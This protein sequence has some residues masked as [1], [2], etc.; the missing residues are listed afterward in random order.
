MENK[1]CEHSWKPFDYYYGFEKSTI[2]ACFKCLKTP[3]EINLTETIL[4]QKNVLEARC[5]M[6]DKLEAELNTKR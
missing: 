1:A 3:A 5:K 6:I 4:T 2:V